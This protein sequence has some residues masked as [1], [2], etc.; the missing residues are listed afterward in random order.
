MLIHLPVGIVQSMTYLSM[1]DGRLFIFV[2]Y[3]EHRSIPSLILHIFTH[4]K[5]KI[6]S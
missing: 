6:Q 3:T 5:Q 2:S 4:Y 1:S